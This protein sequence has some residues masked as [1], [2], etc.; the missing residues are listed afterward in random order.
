MR[1]SF[2]RVA[3][4]IF[5]LLAA[6]RSAAH[7]QFGLERVVSNIDVANLNAQGSCLLNKSVLRAASGGRCGLYGWGLEVALSLSPDTAH[8]QYQ[9]GVGYGQITG[10]QSVNPSL[11]LHGMMRLTPEVSF[12]A[13]RVVN[14]WFMPYMGVHTGLVTLSNVQAYI[15]PGD[16]VASFSA[17]TLQFGATVGLFLP[18]SLY[19]DTGFRYRDFR[20]LEWRLPKGVLPARW[21]KSIIMNALQVTAGYQFDVGG[22]TGKKKK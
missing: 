15:V 1:R 2:P 16:T 3:L 17:T 20:A 12:Y 10:F 8:T 7:A 22:L 21:P 5:F 6:P 11:D 13:T 9:F 18:H 4:P 14:T 19:L